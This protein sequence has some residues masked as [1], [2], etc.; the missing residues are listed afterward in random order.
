MLVEL[1]DEHTKCSICTTNFSCDRDN[2]DPDIRQHLPVLSSSQRCDHWFC[3][4][5]VL[6]EQ[7]R[8][9]EENNGRVP[10]WIKCMHCREKTSFNPA[11]PK[12]HRLLIDLL[13]RAQK[14]AAAP[15][16]KNG[17]ETEHLKTE[18]D[19]VEDDEELAVPSSLPLVH[20]RVKEKP[21]EYD[22]KYS[23]LFLSATPT[24]HPSDAFDIF[25]LLPKKLPQ[26]YEGESDEDFNDYKRALDYA[27]RNGDGSLIASIRN[28]RQ[29]KIN[30]AAVQKKCIKRFQLRQQRLHQH[31][32]RVIQRRLQQ[33]AQCIRQQQRHTKQQHDATQL[34][35]S[36]RLL[37]EPSPRR[38]ARLQSVY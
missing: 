5:C 24:L 14:Y 20:R 33:S 31:K 37:R 18:R 23:D 38:S 2:Q 17:G 26:K 15:R 9:A 4:G 13:A 3:H 16:M 21:S 25:T 19:A 10:K 34:R 30:A 36:P 22:R 1:E 12:Y 11:E 6:R 7:L 28:H 27:C 32:Q 35:R 29:A 8:V